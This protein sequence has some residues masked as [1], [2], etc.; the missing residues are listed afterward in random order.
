M[1][2]VKFI[3]NKYKFASVSQNSTIEGISHPATTKSWNLLLCLTGNTGKLKA[4]SQN[5]CSTLSKMTFYS[6]N[7]LPSPSRA[8][9][10]AQGGG[11]PSKEAE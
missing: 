10:T 4:Q 11:R 2:M 8:A 5:S 9:C 6:C 1:L 3:F 7:L